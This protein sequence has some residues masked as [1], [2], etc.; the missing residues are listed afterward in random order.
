MFQTLPTLEELLNEFKPQTSLKEFVLQQKLSI[1]VSYNS[2]FSIVSQG[3]RNSLMR[4]KSLGFQVKEWPLKYKTYP[5]TY[6]WL[7]ILSLAVKGNDHILTHFHCLHIKKDEV[8][9]ANHSMPNFCTIPYLYFLFEYH[10]FLFVQELPLIYC[11]L[12]FLNQ[13]WP[14][15]LWYSPLPLPTPEP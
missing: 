10:I 6:S 5:E 11:Y 8:S 12:L 15:F 4:S 2:C 1:N 3:L 9:A 7:D 14:S 13:T